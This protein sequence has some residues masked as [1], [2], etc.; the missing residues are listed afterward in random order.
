LTEHLDRGVGKPRFEV[1]HGRSQS[2]SPATERIV[3]EQERRRDRS[4]TDELAKPALVDALSPVSRNHPS[5]VT[6]LF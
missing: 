5:G 1:D 3:G 2:R 6:P 4:L